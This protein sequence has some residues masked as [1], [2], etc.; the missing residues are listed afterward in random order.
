MTRSDRPFRIALLWRGD[1]REPPDNPR[2]ASVFAALADLGMQPEPAVWADDA[3]TE[4]GEQLRN[5]DAVLAWADPLAGEQRR[6]RIDEALRDAAAAGVFVSAHPDVILKM[7]V[8]DVLF[9][10]R[11]LGWGA[12]THRYDTPESFAAAF[13]ARLAR[14]GPRVIKQNRGNGG[15]GVWKVELV[16]PE[17]VRVQEGPAAGTEPREMPLQTFMASCQAY[18]D[19]GGRLID[20]AFQPRLPEGMIRCYM[21]GDCV[22]GFGRQIIRGL[23]TPADGPPGPRIMSGADHP[24]F[25]ALRHMMQDEWT[26]AMAGRLAIAAEDLPVIWDADFLLG[27]KGPAGE[28]SYVLCEINVSSVLPI[29]DEAP[30]AIAA[31]TL[32]RLQATA[33]RQ[34]T[35]ERDV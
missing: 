10:T 14:S 34:P 23:M 12:D 32:R 20:Q 9:T 18:F 3:A 4:I 21:S 5:V 11:D 16:S 2:L 17:A 26:P 6:R 8:K 19:G 30:G 25:Q 22:V 35:G 24:P 27:P 13:P 28:D 29:P 33:I 7:G 1:R 15:I 31:T